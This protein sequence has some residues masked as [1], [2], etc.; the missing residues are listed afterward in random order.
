MSPTLIRSNTTQKKTR[1]NRPRSY[2]DH[3][4][5]HYLSTWDNSTPSSRHIEMFSWSLTRF[6]TKSNQGKHINLM[7]QTQIFCLVL[8]G[9]SF[10]QKLK[11]R[12]VGKTKSNC[13]LR[14]SIILKLVVSSFMV[15]QFILF[16][17]FFYMYKSSESCLFQFYIPWRTSN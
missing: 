15:T 17:I 8:R 1:K 3:Q 2:N 13:F 7:N 10:F 9:K 14:I 4:D 6:K 5:T 16:Y 12:G 11:S